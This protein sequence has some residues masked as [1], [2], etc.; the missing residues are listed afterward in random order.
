M[1][2]PTRDEI[3]R[4]PDDELLRHC[5]VDTFRGSGRGG[6]KRNVTESAVRVTHLAT[7][8]S[9]VND[10]TRSQLQNRARAL[11]QLRHR[12]ALEW[13][14]PA[15]AGRLSLVCPAGRRSDDYLLWLAAVLDLI[16]THCGRISDAA[17]ACGTSTGRLV[18]DLA[19]DPQAWQHL[20]QR[21]LA[22]GLKPLRM[23]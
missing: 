1:P 13:R 3:L 4:M 8:L 5:R 22:A 2:D 23:P 10:E 17:A 18:R 14:Q 7:T 11:R 9:A 19:G 15:P 21:R 6:Q 20:N 12:L 16:E